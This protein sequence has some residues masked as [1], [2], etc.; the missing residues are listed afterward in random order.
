MYP[1]TVTWVSI[2]QAINYASGG[3]PL[4]SS[5]GCKLMQLQF[6]LGKVEAITLRLGLLHDVHQLLDLISGMLQHGLLF[7]G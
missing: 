4:G 1:E 7:S 5:T 2:H 3:C 6:V